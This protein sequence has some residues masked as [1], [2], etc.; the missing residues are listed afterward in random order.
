VI[1]AGSAGERERRV[2]VRVENGREV[3]REV[4]SEKI[5]QPPVPR[6]IAVG[7]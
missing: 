2:R 7:E 4:E 3:S 5:I 1:E 6:V